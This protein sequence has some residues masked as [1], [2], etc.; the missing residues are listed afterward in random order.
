LNN[1][2]IVILAAGK[3]ERLST[4]SEPSPPKLLRKI[5]G[6]PLIIRTLLTGRRAGFSE[7][8]VV[9]GHSG[10]LLKQ[11]ILEEKRVRDLSIEFVDNKDWER[12]NGTSLLKARDKVGDQFV[13]LMGDHVFESRILAELKKTRLDSDLSYLVIDR[14]VDEVFD[15]D[16]ATKVLVED[17]GRIKEIGKDITE[18]NALDTGIFVHARQIFEALQEALDETGQCS[19]SDGN[20][21]LAHRGKLHALDLGPFAWN[22]VDT[23]EA[24]KHAERELF[25]SLVKKEDGRISRYIN[26][27]ISIPMSRLLSKTPLSPNALTVVTLGIG[28][29]SAYFFFL[30]GYVNMVIGA[31]LFQFASVFDGCDGEIARIKFLESKLGGWLDTVADN[32]TYILVFPAIAVGLYKQTGSP[33]YQKSAYVCLVGVLLTIFLA[34]LMT[35]RKVATGSMSDYSARIAK[36]LD[37]HPKNVIERFIRRYNFIVKRNFFALFT[38]FCALTYSLEFLLVG[39]MVSSNIAWACILYLNLRKR[40]KKAFV[41]E[42]VPAE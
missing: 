20:R 36:R 9:L 22:D 15:L 35:G 30:G 28:V 38:L 34:S 41:A 29:L 39:V 33:F 11:A 19:L 4:P 10:E 18:Y 40:I 13:V 8:V 24:L 2:K 5:A 7:F 42:R 1:K 21:R 3:G 6:V 31:L 17:G 26:R 16:D 12:G 27:R 32:T 25:R 23:P 14:R 37:R